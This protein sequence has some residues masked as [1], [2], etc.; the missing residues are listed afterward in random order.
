MGTKDAKVMRRERVAQAARVIERRGMQRLGVV[1][2]AWFN[3][4][5]VQQFAAVGATWHTLQAIYDRG[6]EPTE[7]LL[8][9]FQVQLR[10]MMGWDEFWNDVEGREVTR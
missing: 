8:E 5:D 4:I 1:G 2:A 6:Q 10:A 3:G 9:Q 7:E